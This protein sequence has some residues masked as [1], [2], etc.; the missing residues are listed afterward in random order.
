METGNT[1]RAKE[2]SAPAQTKPKTHNGAKPEKAKA[3]RDTIT[4]P[5]RDS[6]TRVFKPK[7]KYSQVFDSFEK[8]QEGVPA[9]L[10]RER[11]TAGVCTRCGKPNHDAKFCA[12]RANTK[13]A[14]VSPYRALKNKAGSAAVGIDLTSVRPLRRRARTAPALKSGLRDV[15]DLDFD[16]D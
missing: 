8:A 1:S 5:K 3:D 2:G 10:V 12:G 9:N 4:A 14:I 7:R 16:M 13:Q 6:N 15:G 11:R